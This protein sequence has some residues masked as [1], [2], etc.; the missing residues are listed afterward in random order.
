MGIGTTAVL[1]VRGP[2]ARKSNAV[3]SGVTGRARTF[4]F[5]PW[6]PKVACQ[7][8]VQP[9]FGRDWPTEIGLSDPQ[10]GAGGRFAFDLR[11]TRDKF[12]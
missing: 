8:S 10:T 1:S 6:S 11:R 3:V 4:A 12:D 7:S 5:P 9:Q 2:A